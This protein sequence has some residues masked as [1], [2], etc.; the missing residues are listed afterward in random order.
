[1]E[2]LSE[3][4][5]HWLWFRARFSFRDRYHV[6][7][8]VLAVGTSDFRVRTALCVFSVHLNTFTIL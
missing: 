6:L 2:W 8:A 7:L 3:W 4:G 1:M 5:L